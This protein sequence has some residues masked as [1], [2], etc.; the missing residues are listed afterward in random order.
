MRVTSPTA[1]ARC[2]GGPRR[3]R[4]GGP[5]GPPGAW[6]TSA[7]PS[8]SALARPW[9]GPAAGRAR[10]ATGPRGG[11]LPGHHPAHAQPH[12]AAAAAGRA[13][14][15]PG[16]ARTGWS[17][18]APP[19][20]TAGAT[21]AELAELVGTGIVD[22]YRIHQHRADDGRHVTVGRVDGVPVRLDARYVGGRRAHLHRVRRAALLRRVQRGA[23]GGVP[24]PGR[25]RH[26]PGGAQPRRGSPTPG[27]PGSRLEGN[28]VHDFVRA[29]AALLPAHP[30][31]RRGDQQPPRADRG[32]RRAASRRAP[33]RLRLRRARR[34]WPGWTARSTWWSPPTAATPST[35]TCTRR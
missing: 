29:A 13:R 14:T 21:T 9:S 35:A 33:R 15:R 31:A 11:G 24:G 20:P 34:P 18:C 26:R 16:P 10:R 12:R 2:R 23:Q 19:G 27:P 1:A 17:C 6:P 3:R 28:P 4:G 30:L 25:H 32:V 8:P 5:G 22:R 7:P